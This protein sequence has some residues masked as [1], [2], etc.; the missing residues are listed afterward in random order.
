MS[1]SSDHS[2]P[3]PFVVDAEVVAKLAD[4]APDPMVAHANGQVIW[5][6]EAAA[7]MLGFARPAEL[8]GRPILDFV[9]PE[10]RVVVV[11]RVRRMLS[12]GAREPMVPEVFLGRDGARVEVEVSAAPIGDVVLV[13]GRDVTRR[14]QAERE[15]LSAATRFRVFFEAAGEPMCIAREAV[16]LEG[17]PAFVA[18]VGC[19]HG[20]EVRGQ[21]L[22]SFIAPEDHGRIAAFI[23]DPAGPLGKTGTIDG[24]HCLTGYVE[25]GARYVAAVL[26]DVTEQQRVAAERQALRER[27][28]QS[29]RLEAVG[30][31]AAGVAHDFN[32]I[33]ASVLGFADLAMREV[34][35]GSELHDSQVHIRA[36]AL[37]ARN[38]VQQI[39]TFGRQSRTQPRPVDVVGVVRE[40]L[41]LLRGTLTAGVQLAI[42]L[43]L[44]PVIT[45]AD[46]TELHQVVMNLVTNARDALVAGGGRIEVTITSD[47]RPERSVAARSVRWLG[48][49]VTDDGEG[50]DEHT[51]EHL[52]EP[53]LTT[54]R[55]RGGHGLGLAV[56]HGIVSGL[57]GVV[58]V[59]SAP[60][61]G[62]TFRVY[63]PEAVGVPV[64][65]TAPATGGRDGAGERVLLVDDDPTTLLVHT[66]LLTSLG[67]VVDAVRDAELA[68]QRIYA[69]QGRYD[70]VV[71]DQNMP[72]MSGVE[73]AVLCTDRW[74]GTPVL[75]C[76]GLG[77]PIEG[78]A[79]QL[80]A[81]SA[82][83]QKPLTREAL[84][85]AV[86]S[87]LAIGRDRQH[88]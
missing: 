72:T 19:G 30:R 16:V 26:R 11:D 38:L 56:V 75:L 46:P 45:I 66:R 36:A 23:E 1:G 24:M 17:N 39:L 50:M 12:G 52:F 73:L 78:T 35:P 65:P 55:D 32:N 47:A 18:L 77:E 28:Q 74:P 69:G 34:E 67:Y 21:P 15:R 41:G 42:D 59:D 51:R 14:N 31:L 85:E 70:L 83:L 13:V 76:S 86:R 54:K 43:G 29:E 49:R 7:T 80:S 20:D 37:R 82:V 79:D 58:E 40:A 25:G 84:A 3:L 57:G 6:N 68:V 64:A 22:L 87:A 2:E 5:A 63:L 53:Y 27:L 10:T 8:I 33:L 62:T 88:S 44:A 9:A 60:G 81:L 4:L 61:A 48:I 71:T